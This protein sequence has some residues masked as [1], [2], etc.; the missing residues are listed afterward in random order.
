MTTKTVGNDI[1]KRVIAHYDLTDEVLPEVSSM[2]PDEIKE[3]IDA[4]P[5]DSPIDRSGLRRKLAQ[6]LP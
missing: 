4:I 1:D 3:L 2:S 6:F 5:M